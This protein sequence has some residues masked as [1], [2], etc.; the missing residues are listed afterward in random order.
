[1]ILVVYRAEFEAMVEHALEALKER[2]DEAMLQ[3]SV[4]D[5]NPN[6][7]MGLS[8]PFCIPAAPLPA[9]PLEAAV[10]AIEDSKAGVSTQAN[11]S[12]T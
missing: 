6:V 1:M 2:A 9:A 5:G 11:P 3:S 10:L 8:L 7:P 4:G 12:T